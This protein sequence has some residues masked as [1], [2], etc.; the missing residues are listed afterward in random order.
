MGFTPDGDAAPRGTIADLGLGAFFGIATIWDWRAGAVDRTIETDDYQ[1]VLSPDGELLVSL[2]RPACRATS[3]SHVVD[4]WDF[5]TGEHVRS[6]AGHS[7]NVVTAAFSPDGS[8]LASGSADGSVRIWN[9]STGEQE[10]V[11]PGSRAVGELARV[12]CRRNR[13]HLRR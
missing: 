2:P 5:A 11:L 9:V 6:L 1:V 12:Q 3:V 8:Q 4:V 10:L 7:A 13:A